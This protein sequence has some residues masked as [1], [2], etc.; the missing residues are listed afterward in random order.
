ML[1]C[2]VYEAREAEQG[3]W[4]TK[5]PLGYRN[6]IGPDGKKIIAVDPAVAPI[7]AKFP[8]QRQGGKRYS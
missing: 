1:S 7:V 8:M 5:T 6:I 2:L 3:I 4:P